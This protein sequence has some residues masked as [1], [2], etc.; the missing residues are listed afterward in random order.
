MAARIRDWAVDRF[1]LSPIYEQLLD[2]RVPRAAWYTG[3]GAALL[4]LIGVQF[5][6]GAMLAWTYSPAAD[7]A[8]AS[9]TYITEQQIL[10]WFLRG[11][12]YWA[13]GMIMIMLLYHLCRQVL[14]AGYKAPREGTWIVGVL[15]M[16]CLL[17]MAYTG[18]LLRWDE[19]AVYGIR[20]MLHMVS[21]VPIVG[22]P[23]VLTLQGGDDIGPRTLT[24][25][26]ATHVLILPL[27]ILGLIGYH[28]YLIV[29]RGTITRGERQQPVESAE[30]QQEIYHDEKESPRRGEDFFPVTMFKT[31]VMAGVVLTIAVALTLV[32]GPARLYSEAN[33]VETSQ[34]A[35]EWWY[36]WYSGLI[37]LLPPWLAP[38][39]VVLFPILTLA[40]LLALP[41]VDRGPDRGVRARVVW[42]GAVVLAVVAI[43]ALT[44][45]RRRSPFTAWP[46]H[47]PPPI[48]TGVELT[49]SA[50]RGRLMFAK[51]GCNTC[52]P[53]SGHG[54]S[55]GPDFARLAVPRSHSE[56]REYIL[57]PPNGVA[58][59]GYA[60]R[61]TEQEL[62]EVVEFCHVAQTFPRDQ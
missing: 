47:Q 30:H 42:A 34:P 62:R 48:P 60:G 33:L 46:N 36:W 38:W 61:M 21:R 40:A 26:Y 54:P 16:Y 6:T 44:D 59:P 43:L 56:M 52:H 22:E 32:F 9:I 31:G 27:S 17:L 49:A 29:Q 5:A 10:G 3:D 8:Y 1:A 11:L 39:F 7:S 2:R 4:L 15:L 57:R 58:M 45:Y 23:L 25:I 19:R 12:H 41:F 18:Y 24:Q 35:E 50:E 55:I 20:V 51:Y 28:L 53:I 14:V 13:A 37:A